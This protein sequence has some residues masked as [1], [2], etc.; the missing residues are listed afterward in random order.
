MAIFGLEMICHQPN[1]YF[2]PYLE[3]TWAHFWKSSVRG[4]GCQ[5]GASTYKCLAHGDR[6]VLRD[7]DLSVVLAGVVRA[8]DRPHHHPGA[9][10]ITV[11]ISVVLLQ[12]VN[13]SALFSIGPD[14]AH[15]SPCTCTG[16]P[17]LCPPGASAWPRGW[18]LDTGT[19]PPVWPRHS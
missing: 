8:A 5:T 2:W 14:H 9:V 17:P 7:D 15:C 13:V 16:C 3:T 1:V 10:V 12:S 18:C 19:G 4:L 11:V 6:L